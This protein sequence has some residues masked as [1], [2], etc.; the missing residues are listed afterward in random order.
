MTNNSTFEQL[1]ALQQLQLEQ[2]WLEATRTT[3]RARPIEDYLQLAF[4]EN[5]KLDDSID[6]IRQFTLLV[7]KGITPSAS[8]LNALAIRFRHYLKTELF[9]S[10]DAAFNLKR[11]QSVGHPLDHRLAREERGRVIHFMWC[12]RYQAKLNDENLSIE[13]AAGEAINKFGLK[14]SESV[15][16]KNYVDMKADDI[17]GQALE[18]MAGVL[19]N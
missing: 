10:L 14:V 13:S 8:I 19:N 9:V 6:V 3:L 12:L 7:E 2:S 17:F 16:E 4:A 5:T 18:A 15:L 11:K 1:T